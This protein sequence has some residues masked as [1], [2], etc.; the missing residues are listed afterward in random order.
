MNKERIGVAIV[1]D[2]D[3]MGLRE[4]LQ[5]EIEKNPNLKVNLLSR[6]K[7]SRI[8][9]EIKTENPDLVFVTASLYRP[10]EFNELQGFVTKLRKYL[11]QA[12]IVVH[13]P[14]LSNTQREAIFEAGVNC[15]INHT[16]AYEALGGVLEKLSTGE[17]IFSSSVIKKSSS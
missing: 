14:Q 5:R 11:P 16:L 7:T 12:S 17:V 8:R 13:T 9:Q 10:Q 4:K 6:I 3:R 2:R 15:W 1:S